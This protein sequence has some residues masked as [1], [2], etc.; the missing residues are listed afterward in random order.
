[1]KKL[2]YLPL[3]FALVLAP[4]CGDDEVVV[5]VGQRQVATP[6][7]V[8]S[9]TACDGLEKPLPKCQG[10]AGPP[11]YTCEADPGKSCAWVAHCEPIVCKPSACEG[12]E[13]VPPKCPAPS[14]PPS[15]SCEPDA[16][17]VCGWVGHCAP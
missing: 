11:S 1:M 5:G 12:K 14:G 17:S 3:L 15:Y 8:C 13:K 6:A 4:G 2:K 10:P 9:A 7:P 16:N